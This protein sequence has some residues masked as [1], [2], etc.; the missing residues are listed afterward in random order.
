[1][2][3]LFLRGDSLFHANSSA[4]HK[5]EQDFF[6]AGKTSFRMEGTGHDGRGRE[7]R[8]TWWAGKK[9]KM[10]KGEWGVRAPSPN[11]TLNLVRRDRHVVHC[12]FCW[13]YSSLYWISASRLNCNLNCYGACKKSHRIECTL[14]RGHLRY[15]TWLGG[16]LLLAA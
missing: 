4:Q 12:T 15:Q 2:A 8:L 6:G 9:A 3:K 7:G 5:V 10:K 1:M 13:G 14:L 16:Y 11:Q